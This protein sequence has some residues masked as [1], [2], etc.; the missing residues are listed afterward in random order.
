[1]KLKLLNY[2]VTDLVFN[3]SGGLASEGGI[4]DELNMKVGQS[5]SASNDRLF[6]VGFKVA[7]KQKDYS[8]HMEMRFSFEADAVI[9][10]EFKRST[11]PTVN[12][13]A[14]AFPYLRS[15]LSILTM[16]AGFRPV[17]LPS[18]NFVELARKPVDGENEV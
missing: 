1:M 14:I 17:M 10:D 4:D 8:V 2:K 13:P 15:F 16:Q 6:V 9:T 11:F 12:A 5:Y 7:V 3:T 18:V